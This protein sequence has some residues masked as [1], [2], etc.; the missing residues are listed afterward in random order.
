MDWRIAVVL[1]PL[2]LAAGW[3]AFNIGSAA[4]KQ[5]QGFLSK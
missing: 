3:A 2:A 5:I 4:L 1:S